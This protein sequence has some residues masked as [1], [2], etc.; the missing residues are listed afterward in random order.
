MTIDAQRIK[1]SGKNQTRD[2]RWSMDG[3]EKSKE[4]ENEEISNKRLKE[5]K[6]DKMAKNQLV[7]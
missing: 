1:D 4:S 7:P 2:E 3:T 6:N 5:T